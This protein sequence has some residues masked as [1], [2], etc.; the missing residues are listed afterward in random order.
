MQKI[1]IQN[2]T[3]L[4]TITTYFLATIC[5]WKEVGPIKPKILFR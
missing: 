2:N 3:T 1:N 5:D 4:T